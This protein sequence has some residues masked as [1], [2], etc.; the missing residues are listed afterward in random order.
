MNGKLK[1]IIIKNLRKSPEGFSEPLIFIPKP[2]SIE[3]SELNAAY[4]LSSDCTLSFVNTGNRGIFSND[5]SE[6]LAHFLNMN[7]DEEPSSY[8]DQ[9]KVEEKSKRDLLDA[10]NEEAYNLIIRKNK[11]SIYSLSEKGLFYGCQT[12]LQIMKNSFLNTKDLL[13]SSKEERTT[14]LLPEINIKDVPDLKIRGVADDISRGQVFTVEEVG[15]PEMPGQFPEGTID[16]SPP[17]D[18]VVISTATGFLEVP[19]LTVRKVLDSREA[20]STSPR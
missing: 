1:A 14:L 4:I 20:D 6:F 16:L 19:K 18:F 7:I 9:R 5:I 11:I 2:K 12:L 15:G 3:K 10:S 17:Y 8:I 13:E